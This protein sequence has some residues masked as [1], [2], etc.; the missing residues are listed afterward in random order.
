L[1]DEPFEAEVRLINEEGFHKVILEKTAFA[2]ND[3]LIALVKAFGDGRKFA[4]GLEAGS[5]SASKAFEEGVFVGK[6][7]YSRGF[8]LGYQ[9][10]IGK[11]EVVQ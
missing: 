3:E 9:N 7:T 4:V 8:L 2:N 10:P 6:Q 11:L 5:I 1:S